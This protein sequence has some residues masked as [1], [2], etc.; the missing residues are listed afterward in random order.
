MS[1]KVLD[2]HVR[3]QSLYDFERSLRDIIKDLEIDIV[4]YG[5]DCFFRIE[6]DGEIDLYKKVLETDK[7]YSKR[8]KR[9]A[10]A[11]KME[12]YKKKKKEERELREYQRLHK[13]FGEI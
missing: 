9:E 2:V 10:V 1:K 13:K 11:E 8:L 7:E 12:V 4:A 3:Y 6:C 5:K